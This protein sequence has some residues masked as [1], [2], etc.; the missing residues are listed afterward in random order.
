MEELKDAHQPISAKGGTKV[1]RLRSLSNP[2][3][4]CQSDSVLLLSSLESYQTL[5]MT[6]PLQHTL[7]ISSIIPVGAETHLI[8]M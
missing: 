2:P 4:R 3:S 1:V 7:F 5:L 8:F 6:H